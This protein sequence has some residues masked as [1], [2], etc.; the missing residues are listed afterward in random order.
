MDGSEKEECEVEF[1]DGFEPPKTRKQLEE[2]ELMFIEEYEY[3]YDYDNED[4]EN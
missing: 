1:C 2:E 3:D 4:T